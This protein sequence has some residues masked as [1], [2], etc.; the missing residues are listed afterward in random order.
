MHRKPLRKTDPHP[1]EG[2]SQA[3]LDEVSDH[4]EW[5][6]QEVATARPFEEVF[7][8]LASAMQETRTGRGRPTVEAPK[9]AVTLPVDPDVLDAFKAKGKDW[10]KEMAAVLRRAADL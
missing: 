9:V 6:A 1:D 8:E 7:P 3:D 10:R 2:Y 5:T 4:P